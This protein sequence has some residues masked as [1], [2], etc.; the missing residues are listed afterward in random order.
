MKKIHPVRLLIKTLLIFAVANLLFAW[1]NPPVE[2]LSLYNHLFPGRTRFAYGLGDRTVSITD[3]DAL[4]SSHEIS[5]KKGENEYRVVVLGDSSIWGDGL[6]S[7]QTAVTHLNEYQLTCKGKDVK[8]YNLGYP[9]LAAIKDM[10]VLDRTM[11]FEPDAIIWS[12][13]LRTMFPKPPNPFLKANG[14][15]I[16][17]FLDTYSLPPYPYT[18]LDYR[19]KTFYEKTI[20]GRRVELA[21]H[22]KLQ[23]LGGVWTA[24]ETDTA[25]NYYA[26]NESR[27]EPAADLNDLGAD[28]SYR[29]FDGPS[30][31]LVPSLWM[32]Y[33]DT[34]EEIVGEKPLLFVNQPMFI[35][36][37]KNSDLHYNAAY[38][39]WAYD[40]YHSFILNDVIAKDRHLLDIWNTIDFS[41]FTGDTFH[42]SPEGEEIKAELLKNAFQAQI[43]GE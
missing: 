28:L 2:R 31:G 27:P 43:C 17:A 35:A 40:Q 26:P 6:E 22:L 30:D 21:W 13:T 1:L 4:F 42:L 37:G 34:A 24:L 32:G 23:T 7:Y 5:A 14:K 36:T 20:V 41:F 25:T 10:L 15:R 19:P 12:F 9:H 16:F 33:L 39:R 18:E 29:E 3:L 38:P 8:F 11:D